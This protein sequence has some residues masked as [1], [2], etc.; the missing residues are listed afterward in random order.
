MV[1]E[2]YYKTLASKDQNYVFYDL[3]IKSCYTSVVLVLFPE[4]LGFVKQQL[5]TTGLWSYVEHMMVKDKLPFN[6]SVV[7]CCVYRRF[8]QGGAKTMMDS[9]LNT[10]RTDL[11]ITKQAF[12]KQHVLDDLYK[13]A[14]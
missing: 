3:N 12:S 14:V 10:N 2:A 5:E 6:K 1:C 13:K 9:I 4:N 8:F 11:G 7:K